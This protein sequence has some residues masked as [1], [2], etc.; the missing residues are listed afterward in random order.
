MLQDRRAISLKPDD[1]RAYRNL[2]R[3][4]GDRP[5][6][7]FKSLTGGACIPLEASDRR[8]SVSATYMALSK[9]S[10]PCLDLPPELSRK[11]ES[12]EKEEE[13]K[14]IAQGAITG[15]IDCD[16]L[17]ARE[18]WADGELLVLFSK[19]RQGSIA[20]IRNHPF[21]DIAAMKAL[22]LEAHAHVIGVENGRQVLLT[23][24]S[25]PGKA[26]GCGGMM[27]SCAECAGIRRSFLVSDALEYHA[28]K[29]SSR[30]SV[31]EDA[32]LR[33]LRQGFDVPGTRVMS[34]LGIAVDTGTGR[35]GIFGAIETEASPDEIGMGWKSSGNMDGILMLDS[36]PLEKESIASYLRTNRDRMVPQLVTGLVLLGYGRWGFDFLAA[37]DK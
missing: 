27:A 26:E 3:Q 34:N 36:I 33:R 28:M 1:I 11:A 9:F 6:S 12:I 20:A 16:R 10:V 30:G 18:I 8:V 13:E 5:V 32:V 31:W 15:W 19:I 24:W 23:G 37:A 25:M 29:D 7:M 35:V 14:L 2:A 21:E 4:L 22:T 17:A